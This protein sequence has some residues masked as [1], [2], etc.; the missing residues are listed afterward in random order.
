M[1]QLVLAAALEEGLD[2]LLSDVSQVEVEGEFL[3]RSLEGVHAV[4]AALAPMPKEQERL[5]VALLNDVSFFSRILPLV[6]KVHVLVEPAILLLLSGNAIA[7]AG[8]VTPGHYVYLEDYVQAKRNPGA[9]VATTAT[10]QTLDSDSLWQARAALVA[11][12][13]AR[14]A[15]N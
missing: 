6:P 1:P 5:A 8:E 11:G 2:E 13:V 12:A 14:I 9:V 3:S 7:R 4:L 15:K 10:P